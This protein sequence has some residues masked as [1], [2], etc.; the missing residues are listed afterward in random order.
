MR[1]LPRSAKR[2]PSGKSSDKACAHGPNYPSCNI[3]KLTGIN[4]ITGEVG[5]PFVTNAGEDCRNLCNITFSKGP[6]AKKYGT[7]PKWGEAQKADDNL[8]RRRLAIV[9]EL[10]ARTKEALDNGK[11]EARMDK[12]VLANILSKAEKTF[13]QKTKQRQVKNDQRFRPYDKYVAKCQKTPEENGETVDTLEYNDG[14]TVLGVWDDRP[15][16]DGCID[17]D[18]LNTGTVGTEKDVGSLADRDGLDSDGHT[19][20]FLKNSGRVLGG[21][22]PTA[23]MQLVGPPGPPKK[24]HRI[25]LPAPP[26]EPEAAPGVRMDMQDTSSPTVAPRG[27][28]RQPP[29]DDVLDD[30][31]GDDVFGNFT[32]PGLDLGAA[33]DGE[34]SEEAAAENTSTIAEKPTAVPHPEPGDEY[35]LPADAPKDAKGAVK[36][37]TSLDMCASTGLACIKNIMNRSSK[38]PEFKKAFDKSSKDIGKHVTAAAGLPL[39]ATA[40]EVKDVDIVALVVDSAGKV[41]TSTQL[42]NNVAKV[43]A[44][45]KPSTLVATYKFVPAMKEAVGVGIEFPFLSHA[46]RV[47]FDMELA[48]GGKEGMG[49][50]VSFDDQSQICGVSAEDHDKAFGVD[51]D[52]A[53]LVAMRPVVVEVNQWRVDQTGHSWIWAVKQQM[54]CGDKKELMGI[55]CASCKAVKLGPSI[56]AQLTHHAVGLC[57]EKKPVAQGQEAASQMNSGDSPKIKGDSY[58]A[59]NAYAMPHIKAA[60]DSIATRATDDGCRNDIRSTI[61]AIGAF[62]KGGPGRPTLDRLEAM[63]DKLEK[64]FAACSRALLAELADAMVA[65]LQSAASCIARAG[66]EGLSVWFGAM[67]QVVSAVAMERLCEAAKVSIASGLKNVIVDKKKGPEEKPEKPPAK[68]DA[69]KENKAMARKEQQRQKEAEKQRQQ[70]HMNH[71]SRNTRMAHTPRKPTRNCRRRL[72]RVLGGGSRGGKETRSQGRKQTRRQ[73]SSW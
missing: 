14:R 29:Q 56:V 42:N 11:S 23:N 60:L 66:V 70:Q 1:F 5:V 21:L 63:F 40:M 32:L 53:W 47:R 45:I 69:N 3:N 37:L 28:K 62:V 36:L 27:S 16:L 7:V 25:A 72:A 10:V 34:N 44:E 4:P 61:L 49:S 55:C 48:L 50:C 64:S 26:S 35:K 57:P 68:K 58:R 73:C 30:E 18:F 67:G 54:A 12:N 43:L 59:V 41:H 2:S 15:E 13:V 6:E 9:V 33:T 22:A 65:A 46:A 19:G 51:P 31:E 24:K 52:N 71:F 38:M 8:E 39:R 17:V 20:L